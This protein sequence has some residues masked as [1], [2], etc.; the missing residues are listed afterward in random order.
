MNGTILISG[1]AGSGKD[2]TA[3]FMKEELEKRGKKVLIIKYGDAVKHV[4]R[5][6]W[7][8]NGEK[9]VIGRSLLQLIGTDMVRRYNP[10]LWVN[11]VVGLL[12]SFEP[13]SDFD[14]AIVSD[15]RFPNEVDIPLSSL[16]NCVAIRIERTNEDGT[17]WVNPELTDAQ[18]QHPSETS[19]DHYAFD[20]ILHNDEGLD[21][22][23]EGAIAI[24]KDLGYIKE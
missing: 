15:V 13:Y 11:F 4:L 8:W 20:Y 12:R 6:Y 21:N 18:R 5:S 1:K 22:L 7:N 24:L 17:A 3:Q 2:A 23:R 10:N 9:D 19:L 14:I 16:K